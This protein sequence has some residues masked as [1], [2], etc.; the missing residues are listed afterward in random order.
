MHLRAQSTDFC[1]VINQQVTAQGHPGKATLSNVRH[2]VDALKKLIEKENLQ[3]VALPRL[4]T[5]VGGLDWEEV[6]K[7]I[8]EH[9]GDLPA[10]VY[11]YTTFSKGVSGENPEQALTG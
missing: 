3:S 4:A 11:V 6:K 2:S 5:G 7:V 10:T 1:V 8:Y 9:L